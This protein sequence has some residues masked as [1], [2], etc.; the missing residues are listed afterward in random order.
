MRKERCVNN[1]FSDEQLNSCCDEL[2]TVSQ[3][4]DFA[5]SSS[6]FYSSV[7]LMLQPLIRTIK[8]D[9]SVVAMMVN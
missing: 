6:V 5:S 9:I 3:C 2:A 1:D 7:Q 4:W 8:W